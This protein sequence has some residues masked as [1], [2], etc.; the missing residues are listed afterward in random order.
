MKQDTSQFLATFMGSLS[1]YQD[2]TKSGQRCNHA[3]WSL[4]DLCPELFSHACCHQ[5]LICQFFLEHSAHVAKKHHSWD[6]S[7][8]RRN[9]STFTAL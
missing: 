8:Q 5:D 3:T 9:D 7:I 1:P 4:V 6:L 2:E